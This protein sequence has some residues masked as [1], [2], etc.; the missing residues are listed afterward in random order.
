M[1]KKLKEFWCDLAHTG[2]I[3]I[4]L[5]SYQCPQCGRVIPYD[6]HKRGGDCNN[7]TAE[8]SGPTSPIFVDSR[9]SPE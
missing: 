6:W 4:T 9:T 5:H 2:V 8:K 7:Y 1:M 3:N